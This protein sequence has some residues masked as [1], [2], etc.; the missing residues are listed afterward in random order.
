MIGA[1]PHRCHPFSP[2]LPPNWLR[3]LGLLKEL[4]SVVMR[5]IEFFVVGPI[6][7][8]IFRSATS[9]PPL[10]AKRCTFPVTPLAPLMKRRKVLDNFASRASS[11]LAT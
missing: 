4:G 3:L 2:G 7:L 9:A 6:N 8:M 11:D 10:S 1:A 5:R